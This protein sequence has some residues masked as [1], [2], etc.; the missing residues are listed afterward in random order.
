MWFVLDHICREEIPYGLLT[1]LQVRI[2]KC[3]CSQYFIEE[4]S[5]NLKLDSEK[6]GWQKPCTFN[7]ITTYCMYLCYGSFIQS[8]ADSSIS[9]PLERR[10]IETAFLPKNN[11]GEKHPTADVISQT[12]QFALECETCNLGLHL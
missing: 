6:A 5:L 2:P 3:F 4:F 10:G 8:S 12:N 9:D 11:A 1:N 7:A